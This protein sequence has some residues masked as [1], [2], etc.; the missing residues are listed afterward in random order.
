ME[1]VEYDPPRQLRWREEDEDGIFNVVYRLEATS[2]GTR[3]TQ[4]D[5]IDWKIS[6][7]ALPIA[8]VMVSRDIARQLGALKK[9][10]E[11]G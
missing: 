7:L 6:K 11:G 1:V 10:L 2:S 8:R 4:I 3:L 5:D 9:S